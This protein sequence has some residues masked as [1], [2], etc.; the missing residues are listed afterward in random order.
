MTFSIKIT[1]E[2]IQKNRLSESVEA[3]LL[4]RPTHNAQSVIRKTINV[5]IN[6]Y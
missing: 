3:V 5:L 4:N 1:F 2:G 6:Y